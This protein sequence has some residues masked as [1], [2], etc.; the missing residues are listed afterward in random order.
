MNTRLRTSYRVS[1]QSYMQLSIVVDGIPSGLDKL[2]EQSEII[3]S[4]DPGRW[5]V[6]LS[7]DVAE[8]CQ[9]FRLICWLKPYKKDSSGKKFIS[10]YL[11]PPQIG[12][13][14][15]KVTFS[16]TVSTITRKEII[17]YKV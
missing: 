8:A 16:M 6:E 4:V 9:I 12:T 5:H 2:S 7:F 15:V 11:K 1:S 14:V 10:T 13:G 3:L 17:S